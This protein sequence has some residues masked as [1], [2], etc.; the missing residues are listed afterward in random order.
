MIKKKIESE[1]EREAK[2]EKYIERY[3]KEENRIR[4]RKIDR[5]G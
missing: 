5:E 1:K 3:D 2:E 4:E